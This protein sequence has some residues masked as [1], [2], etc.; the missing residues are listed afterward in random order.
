M[1]SI[2]PSDKAA[3]LGQQPF[4]LNMNKNDSVKFLKESVA[5][6]SV[7]P[8]FRLSVKGGDDIVAK[9]DKVDVLCSAIPNHSK[10]TMYPLT[11]RSAV[12]QAQLDFSSGRRSFSHGKYAALM[13]GVR[14]LNEGVTT[15]NTGIATANTGIAGLE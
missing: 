3:E 5:S 15:A 10:I 11:Q 12:Q 1:G 7:V 14:N 6:K 4:K 2:E 13:T 9:R 8:S